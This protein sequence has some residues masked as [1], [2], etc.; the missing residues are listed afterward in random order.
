MRTQIPMLTP[1]ILGVALLLGATA[2]ASAADRVPD[3]TQIV[4]TN[5]SAV[6][7]IATTQTVERGSGNLPEGLMERLPPDSPFREFFERFE[8][9]GPEQQRERSSL[10]SGFVISEDGYV[11]TNAHVVNEADQ[12]IVKMDDRQEYEAEVVGVDKPS[13]VALLKIDAEGLDTVELG[14]SEELNVGQWVLAIGSPFGLEHTATQGIVSA[15]NRNLPNDTYTPFIQTDVAVNPG[16]SGG[17]LFN[18]EGE[19][20]G[21]N[22]QIFSRSGGYMGLSFAVPINT[23]M[24]VVEQLKEHGRV[25]RGYLGVNI[26]PIDRGLAESFSLD[27]PIGALVSETVPDSPAARAGLKAGD[28]ILEFDGQEVA[29]AADLPPMVG[30]TPAGE[31]VEVVVLRDG[32]R[33]TIEVELGELSEY[34]EDAEPSGND[35][36]GAEESS[37]NVAVRELTQEERQELGLRGRGLLVQRVGAGPIAEAGIRPGDILLRLGREELT[38]VEQLKETVKS[39]PRDQPVAVQIRRGDNTLFVSLTLPT[40]D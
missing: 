27:K 25:E 29:E 10:G 34:D 22:S 3:F 39:L 12:I 38:S 26:Q 37:L 35:G 30:R 33:K 15:L 4:E 32:E 40:K 14:D 8:R 1:A 2:P 20:I 31:T 21:I 18:G 17:P 11:L 9:G 5:R 6:V 7:H 16:N 24:D 23:A 19:V 13:D 28:V 36:D